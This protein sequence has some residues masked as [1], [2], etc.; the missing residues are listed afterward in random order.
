MT[1]TSLKKPAWKTISE[2]FSKLS[3]HVPY[4]H[5]KPSSR[6]PHP[7]SLIATI[8]A[9]H[10]VD[11]N[12]DH[13]SGAGIWFKEDDVRNETLKIPS[14]M[15]SPGAGEIGAVLHVVWNTPMVNPLKFFI[16]SKALI[17]DL[18]VNL[19]VNEETDWITHPNAGLMRA[20]VAILRE[21]CSHT[22]FQ[23]WNHLITPKIKK[24]VS[25]L[26]KSGSQKR[27]HD[28]IST[29]IKPEFRL[30]GVKL[31][32]GN[33][34]LFY[35]AIRKYK[36]KPHQRRS[37]QMNLTKIQYTICDI[38]SCTPTPM[39]IWNSIRNKDIPK[40]IR[41]FLWKS[42]HS[43]YKIRDFWENIP[44]FENRGRCELCG[45]PKNMEH[46]LLECDKSLAS[47]VIWGAAKDI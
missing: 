30:S 47:K 44:N 16:N 11:K 2:C 36:T 39:Q 10:L 25:E 46:I 5:P 20:T 40:S 21:Q 18:T 22:T 4:Q 1:P 17:K 45:E 42:I 15:A 32:I 12:G 27:T 38:N 24:R 19:Q 9:S 8:A 3:P 28:N 43:T 34:R 13:V 7:E 41:G 26:A 29:E 33:Q 31:Q 35:Q 23:Q 37:M 14:Q 6:D